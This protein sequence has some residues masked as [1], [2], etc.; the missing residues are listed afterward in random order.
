MLPFFLCD[1]SVSLSFLLLLCTVTPSETSQAP[2]MS[3]VRH[4]QPLESKA[5]NAKPQ[6]PR[7]KNSLRPRPA[8]LPPQPER[9]RKECADEEP[10]Q[11]HD[12]PAA[13]KQRSQTAATPLP[14]PVGPSTRSK[15]QA[16]RKEKDEQLRE[17][18]QVQSAEWCR[19]YRRAFKTF[20]FYLD[21]ID[22]HKGHEISRS[23]QDLGSVSR[24]ALRFTMLMLTIL[25]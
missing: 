17:N 13:K 21:G 18:I 8:I 14:P 7:G 6:L 15:K 24:L 23:L 25:Q 5:S 19:K 4:R 20:V 10:T 16:A 12:S 11:P 1:D 22:G 9:K 2:A 3:L